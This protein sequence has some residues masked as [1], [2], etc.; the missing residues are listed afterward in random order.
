MYTIVLIIIIAI[1]ISSSLGSGLGYYFYTKEEVKS[2][3]DIGWGVGKSGKSV[4]RRCV[5][6]YSGV[7]TQKCTPQGGWLSEDN[8]TILAE[9]AEKYPGCD[10]KTCRSIIDSYRAQKLPYNTTDF[11]ECT[12]CPILSNENLSS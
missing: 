1:C 3:P 9:F 6:G 7:V 11:E 10:L 4:E 12:G 8:C 2:C 5:P